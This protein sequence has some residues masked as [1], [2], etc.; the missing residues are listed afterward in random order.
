MLALESAYHTRER[1]LTL[2]VFWVPAVSRE[3]FEQAY[4]EIGTLLRIPGIADAKADV[5]QL[6]KARLSDEGS[7]QWLIIIDNANDVSVLLNPLKK[8]SG[9]NRLMDYLP[10]SRKGSIIFTTRTRKAAI[11][12]AGSNV[13]ELGELHGQ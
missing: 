6:V 5:K 9:A 3:S 13:V 2:A 11:D 10:H 4:R 7:G 8:E 12:L 1:Q